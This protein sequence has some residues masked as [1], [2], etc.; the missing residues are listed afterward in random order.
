MKTKLCNVQADE[1]G[2]AYI[3]PAQANTKT[4][5]GQLVPGNAEVIVW[6]ARRFKDRSDETIMIRQEND[7]RVDLVEV[8][9][10]QLYALIE[11]LNAVVEDI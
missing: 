9:F 1:H 7:G 11:A 4:P 5:G 8:T 3:I 2:T 10:S 6:W